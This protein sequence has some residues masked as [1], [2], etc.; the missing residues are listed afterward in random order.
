MAT[1]KKASLQMQLRATTTRK[2]FIKLYF[3]CIVQ[4]VKSILLLEMAR[5][6]WKMNQNVELIVVVTQW[7]KNCAFGCLTLMFA[8]T[9]KNC[10]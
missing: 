9:T 6:A 3:V 10:A 1:S 7:D 4:Y 5:T 2:Y 8:R